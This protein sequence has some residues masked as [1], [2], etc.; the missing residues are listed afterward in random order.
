MGLETYGKA[1]FEKI[2]NKYL[3]EEKISFL[4]EEESSLTSRIKL[5]SEPNN[6]ASYIKKRYPFNHWKKYEDNYNY[7]TLNGFE[8]AS[9]KK[10]SDS[11]L[12]LYIKIEKQKNKLTGDNYL[13]I[14]YK[15][16]K[17]LLGEDKDYYLGKA[18]IQNSNFKLTDFNFYFNPKRKILSIFKEKN[19]NKTQKR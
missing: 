3:N 1:F 8:S 7:L 16:P 14:K 11:D 5:L 15:G 2:E 9:F 18:F 6:L 19:N 12:W 10:E 17:Q 13:I 4:G